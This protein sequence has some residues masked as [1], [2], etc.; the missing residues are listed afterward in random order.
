MSFDPQ[1]WLHHFV[2]P[3]VAGGDVRVATAIGARELDLVR[4]ASLE[5]DPAVERIA[6]ARHAVV[7][8]LLLAPR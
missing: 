4:T 8:E 5:R 1:K 6:E 3:L 2:L 7:S